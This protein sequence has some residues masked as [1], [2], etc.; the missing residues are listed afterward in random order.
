MY[1]RKSLDERY[2]LCVLLPSYSA[3]SILTD[4]FLV[5]HTGTE[6][7]SKIL[8]SHKTH[9]LCVPSV[10][11]SQAVSAPSNLLYR[12]RDQNSYLFYWKQGISVSAFGSWFQGHS[13]DLQILMLLEQTSVCLAIEHSCPRS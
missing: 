5:L 13:K 9:L 10:S 1:T 8:M 6:P 2:F 11:S 3:I 12:P 7:V 4:C